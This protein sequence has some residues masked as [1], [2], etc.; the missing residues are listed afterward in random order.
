MKMILKNIVG[1]MFFYFYFIVFWNFFIIKEILENQNNIVLGVTNG[2]I[3]RGLFFLFF[4]RK[5]R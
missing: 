5:N 2:E 1:K 4:R 3:N